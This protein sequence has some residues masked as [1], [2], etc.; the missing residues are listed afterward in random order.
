MPLF[1]RKPNAQRL[2]EQAMTE[3]AT[4]GASSPNRL[5]ASWVRLASAIGA[6]F[7][8]SL[9][10][11]GEFRALSRTVTERGAARLL[12]VIA[13]TTLDSFMGNADNLA[14]IRTF[15]YQG[16]EEFERDV[17]DC[18]DR[19]GC[20]FLT[21]TRTRAIES[22]N[23]G[24]SWSFGFHQHAFIA[25]LYPEEDRVFTSAREAI[26]AGY[27]VGN[28]PID[29]LTAWTALCQ[30][31]ASQ[32]IPQLSETLQHDESPARRERVGPPPAEQVWLPFEEYCLEASL[33][34]AK[35]TERHLGDGTWQAG[36]ARSAEDANAIAV[37]GWSIC[38]E[39]L[40]I[41]YLACDAYVFRRFGSAARDPLMDE[42]A[43]ILSANFKRLSNPRGPTPA[44]DD[45]HAKVIGGVL[46]QYEE[47]GRM[48]S[49]GGWLSVVDDFATE[50]CRISDVAPADAVRREI[51]AD[52][53]PI[54]ELSR[55]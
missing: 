18:F 5:V 10:Q 52:V 39:F 22:G 27:Q 2:L 7:A 30:T 13:A 49:E 32:F 25:V 53:Q 14:A 51:I 31:Y 17:L 15:G 16:N 44:T 37:R 19:Y 21:V 1:T 4:R 38:L 47:Y 20:T 26:S 28:N 12:S 54:V 3:A 42:V 55:R 33:R 24:T 9:L 29:A 50:I 23:A 43:N 8:V 48:L 46:A 34:L 40:T 41:G 35:E 6:G 45:M 36:T 11:Q